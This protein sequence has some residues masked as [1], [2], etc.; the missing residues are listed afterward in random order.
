[1]IETFEIKNSNDARIWEDDSFLRFPND[2]IL[3]FRIT[4]FYGQL[5]VSGS[6][7]EFLGEFCGCQIPRTRTISKAIALTGNRCASEFVTFSIA[8]NRKGGQRRRDM[9]V[10]CRGTL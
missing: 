4:Q 5:G 8:R 2:S 3:N 9:R 6:P 7:L 10:E 1:M